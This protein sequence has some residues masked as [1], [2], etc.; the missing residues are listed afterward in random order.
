MP[1]R[2]PAALLSMRDQLANFE[3][4]PAADKMAHLSSL[5]RE[6]GLP[7]PISKEGVK[8]T[9]EFNKLSTQI[10]LQQVA[11]LGGAGT[12]DKLAA[13][14]KG[15]PST[16][17]SKQ[18]NKAVTALMLGN[19]DAISAKNA[20]WQKWLASGKTPD[21]YGQFSTQFNRIY[22][23]RVFQGVHGPQ[24]PCGDDPEHDA[25]KEGLRRARPH[26]RSGRL[27]QVA[28]PTSC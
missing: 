7:A 1:H 13:G 8:A 25:G 11:Q 4:G 12:D 28:W 15:N 14:I 2:P 3:T 16:Y 20:A 9:E 10:V 6:F 27:D 23:P 21:S 26:R 24:G 19:E 5:A 22:D 18:G 17:L